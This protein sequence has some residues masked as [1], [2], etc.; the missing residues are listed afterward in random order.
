MAAKH[1]ITSLFCAGKEDTLGA[2]NA[3]NKTCG[4]CSRAHPI[5][6]HRKKYRA[7]TTSACNT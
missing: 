1:N 5:A 7:A 2:D 3:N 6:F 4:N